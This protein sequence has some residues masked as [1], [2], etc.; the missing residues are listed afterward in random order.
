MTLPWKTWTRD[1]LPS[2]TRTWTSTSSP[3]AKSGRS[4]RRL[5]WSM[6]SVAFMARWSYVSQEG[7]SRIG[8]GVE[9]FQQRLLVGAE[10]A[11]GRD[12][13][14]PGGDGPVQGLRPPPALDAGVIARSEDVR[15]VP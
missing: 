7:R 3:A 15:D 14:R 6:R 2:L 12:Q 9:L 4:G 11:P 8:D 1:R 5:S 13:V 10:P